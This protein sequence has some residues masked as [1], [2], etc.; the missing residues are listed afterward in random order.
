MCVDTTYYIIMKNM[1]EDNLWRPE[2]FINKG[3]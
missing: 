1:H 2:G 3:K